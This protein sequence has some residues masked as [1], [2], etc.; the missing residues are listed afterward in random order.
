MMPR[1][2][3][4]TSSLQELNGKMFMR[5]RLVYKLS[6]SFT[7]LVTVIIPYILDGVEDVLKILI[8]CQ[9]CAH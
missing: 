3:C 4:S 5:R 9:N 1:R 8:W 6:F 7:F 2:S